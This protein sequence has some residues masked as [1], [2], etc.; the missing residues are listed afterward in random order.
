MRVSVSVGIYHSP[1]EFVEKAEK[2]VHPFDMGDSIKDD[3]KKA[4]FGLLT[5]GPMELKKQREETFEKYEKVAKELQEKEDFLHAS[6]RPDR[7]KIVS[8][9][10]FFLMERMAKDA[11]IECTNLLDML[12][13]WVH[14]TGELRTVACSC[15]ETKSQFFPR[16]RS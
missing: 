1:A 2:Q 6:M 7:E 8:E 3:L 11:G 10:K 4:V 12:V 13:N 14:L 5:S 16:S 9:K 15:P